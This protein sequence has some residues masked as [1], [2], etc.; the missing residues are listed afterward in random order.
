MSKRDILQKINFGGRVAEDEKDLR[1]YFVETDQWR[2]I[3]DGEI[4][5]IYGPKGSGKSAI[6]S[7]L[8][9]R[10]DDLFSRKVIVIAAENPRG[11]PVFSDLVADPP[12]SE[13]EFRFLWK[14][15]FLSLLAYKFKEFDIQNKPA[16]DVIEILSDVGL[17]EESYNLRRILRSVI[18]YVRK[19][20]DVGSIEG[21]LQ[22]SP[23]AG[24]P[25]GVRGKI[26][27]REPSSEQRKLGSLSADELL[28][29]SNDALD[30][31]GYSVWIALDRL[32]V[33]FAETKDLEQNALRALFRV[34]LDLLDNNNL[35]VKIFLRSDIWNRITLSGFRE[36]SHI[37]RKI[38]IEWDS[39]SLM[40]LIIRR[41]LN[42]EAIRTTYNVDTSYILMNV[43]RQNDLFYKIFPRQVDSGPKNPKT[44][45]WM[46]GRTKDGTGINAPREL[47]HLITSATEIQIRN[48]EQG[49]L[50][51]LPGEILF[52]GSSLKAALPAVSRERLEQTI[53]AEYPEYREIIQKLEGNKTQ[54]TSNTLS[55]IWSV[56]KDRASDYASSLV[57]IGLFQRIG[58]NENPAYWM[59]FL[60]R[61][62][63]SMV[64]GSAE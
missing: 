50:P 34:Y 1:S 45:D 31:V 10:E 42:N 30:E 9:D 16:K 2:K 58:T 57:D 48:F 22:F 21:S 7:L 55:Q 8:I 64:Q 26:T 11:T 59:P 4:D 20:K 44:F 61:D 36:A 46:L 37:T 35:S 3:F 15:Y 32:D 39:Q 40:N 19:F 41:A 17:I 28:N 56:S 12:T 6:Y 25:V 43:E 60:Y 62:A 63:L 38:V 18:D 47:V 23:E 5:I 14:L 51:E 13:E 24:F 53:Y 29:L 52:T 54:Q 33:A 49:L 27:F